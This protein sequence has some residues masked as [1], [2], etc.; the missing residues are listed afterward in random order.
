MPA[1]VIIDVTSSSKWPMNLYNTEESI[2]VLKE[3]GMSVGLL[4]DHDQRYV[5]GSGL[6]TIDNFDPNPIAEK[7]L[8]SKKPVVEMNGVKYYSRSV[9]NSWN[10]KRKITPLRGMPDLIT[11]MHERNLF[12]DLL[13]VREQELDNALIQCGK[14][15]QKYKEQGKQIENKV[16][17]QYRDKFMKLQLDLNKSQS[18]VRKHKQTIEELSTELETI[19]GLLGLG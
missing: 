4:L 15:V 3:E 13:S 11:T 1:A 8:S 18:A 2:N 16:E 6:F 14:Y 9:F 10:T 7:W 5:P 12:L 19:K 17:K